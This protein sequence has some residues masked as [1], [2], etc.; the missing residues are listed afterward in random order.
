MPKSGPA[1]RKLAPPSIR[2]SN[3]E[4]QPP[5]PQRR[6]EE[7]AFRAGSGRGSEG[8]RAGSGRK[9]LYRDGLE[10]GWRFAAEFLAHDNEVRLHGAIGYI[11]PADNLAGRERVIF[12]ER[13]RKT[14]GRAR[15]EASRSRGEPADDLLSAESL[16]GPVAGPMMEG[17]LGGG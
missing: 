5:S 15:A 16:P 6:P 11:T 13:D 8:R 12:A 10:C 14:G 7:F 17:G 9:W 2:P 3:H 4:E 1:T